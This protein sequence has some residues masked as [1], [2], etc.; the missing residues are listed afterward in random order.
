MKKKVI[1]LSL[2]VIVIVVC[3]I[4][5]TIQKTIAIKSPLLNVYEQLSNPLNWEK[6]RPDIKKVFIA[7]SNKISIQKDIPTSFRIKYAGQE[8]TVISNENLFIINDT[9]GDNKTVNYSYTIVPDQ[10]QM[11]VLD[12]H[13]KKTLVTAN[14]KVSLITY[15]IGRLRPVSFSDTH[16]DDFKRYMETDSLLYG[17]KIIRT[18]VP[19]NNLI[20]IDNSVLA[21]NKFNE[22]AKLLSKLQQYLKTHNDIKQM[23][24]LIAQFIPKGLDSAQIK[25]G[26][27]VNKKVESENEIKYNRMPK[28]GTFYI[29]GFKGRFNER[30]RVYKGLQKY[31]TNHLYQTVLLPFETYLDNKLPTSD[32]D[33]VNIEVIFPSYF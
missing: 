28:G 15:L 14:K 6:W 20:V 21:K 10:L 22:A 2:L 30:Q 7:D 19:E 5:V 4:P 23:R 12:N 3:F 27:F 16:I 26:I 31:F 24:P 18:G 1:L 25:V 33:E 29:A 17:C 13:P 9:R 11:T 32:T 8:L